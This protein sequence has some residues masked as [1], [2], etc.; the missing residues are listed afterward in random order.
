M[1]DAR[2]RITDPQGH[3][4]V[5]IDKALF[6]IGRRT[7]ADLQIVSTDVSR[8]HAEIVRDGDQYVLRDRGSRYGTFV[9]GEA[10][11]ERPLSYGDRIRLGRTDAIEL[12]FQG[13]ESTGL[14][15]TAT[16]IT[17][18]RQM[19]AI[20]NGIRALGSGRVLP[21]VLT[22][23]LDSAI[24]VTK[25]ER[26]FVMLATSTGDLEFKVARGRGGVVLPGTSFTTSAKI[27][28]EVF[29]TGKGTIVSD[30]MDGNLAAA[31]DGTI[32]VGIRYVLCVPLRVIPMGEGSDAQREQVIGVLYL[33]GR[34]RSTMYSKATLA[35]LEAF[36]TQA[37]LAIESARLYAESAEKARIDRDLRV[38]AEIQRALNADPA[39]KGAFCDLAAVSVPCRTV[40]GDFFD[41]L[42]LSDGGFAFALGDVAGKGPP[43]ALQAA[44]VQTNFAALVTVSDGPASTMTRLNTALLRRAVEARFATMFHGVLEPDGRLRYS[45]AGQEAPIVVQEGGNALAL[46]TGG[47]VLGLLPRATYESDSVQLR[48]GDVVVVISDGV[49]EAR[50]EEG[51]EFGRDRLV[52]ALNRCHGM[53]PD[54]VIDAVMSVVRKFVGGAPQADDITALVVRYSGKPS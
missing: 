3:R 1:P 15:D 17:D 4:L 51:E 25:A 2:L 29:T 11:T 34:E 41:Y 7:A 42:E 9:N 39:Y 52:E 18:L 16:D 12:V 50:S 35:S 10:V 27:P 37:A 45:N 20:L 8:E 23:V 28:R 24:E 26:G 13:D 48:P 54:A 46:E 47:P 30:L 31:H 19:A 40:G 14:R 43:A 21:E 6:T 32:A 44:S 49:T 36:A 22:L 33:D 5:T 38:A 53:K